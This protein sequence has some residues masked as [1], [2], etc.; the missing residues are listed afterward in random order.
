MVEVLQILLSGGLIYGI[1]YIANIV[2]K[3]IIAA[4]ISFNKDISDNKA[5]SITE[6]MSQDINI[7]FHK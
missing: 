2:G 7:N 5:K 6:M 1:C 3:C 4:I